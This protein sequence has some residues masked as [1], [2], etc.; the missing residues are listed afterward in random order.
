MIENTARYIAYIST[1]VLSLDSGPSEFV[2]FR[3]ELPEIFFHTIHN[4][5]KW[6][7]PS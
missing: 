7:D 3:G 2:N 1:S 4:F 5:Q 6:K